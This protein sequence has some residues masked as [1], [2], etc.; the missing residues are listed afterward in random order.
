MRSLFCLLAVAVI[1][2]CQTAP[3]SQSSAPVAAAEAMDPA[4]AFMGI[5]G[6]RSRAVEVDERGNAITRFPARDGSVVNF[7][8][9][10]AVLERAEENMPLYKP[11]YWERI[12]ELDSDAGSDPSFN[13]MPAGVPRMGPPQRI[14]RDGDTLVL[15]YTGSDDTY[16]IIPTDGRDLSEEQLGDI[17]WKGYST[18][19]F[20]GERLV[21]TSKAFN[22]ASWLGWPAWVHSNE[23]VVTETLWVEDDNLHWSATVEDPMLLEP[24]TTHTETR[25]RTTDPD[26]FFW[27]TPPCDE[28]D[29]EHIVDRDVRG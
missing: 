21:I 24:W 12:R 2:G 10:F 5:W 28:Q 20:E 18:G 27:E 4:D 14:A 29:L 3:V 25:A 7:E 19:T 9:D 15:L 17:T 22:D 23:M 1:V 6:Y 8:T 11:R 16:R 13:C 26:V